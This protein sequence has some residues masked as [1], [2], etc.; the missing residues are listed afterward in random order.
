MSRRKRLPRLGVTGGIGSGKSTALAY[1]R[2]LGAAV[3]SSDDVVHD[4]LEEDEIVAAIRERFGDEVVVDGVV[5]RPALAHVVFEDRE[6]LDWLEALLHPNVRRRVEQWARDEV[7]L[8]ELLGKGSADFVVL[9]ADGVQLD[10]FGTPVDS[11]HYRALYQGI[12]DD[13]NNR[14][15]KSWS[16]FFGDWK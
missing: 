10:F 11:L 2:Q 14:R 15:R 6:A 9:C 1:L 3:I 12:A 16:K 13:L 5:S 4:L 8:C 7:E